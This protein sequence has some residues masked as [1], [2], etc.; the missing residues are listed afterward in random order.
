MPTTSAPSS[1]AATRAAARSQIALDRTL[2]LAA[3]ASQRAATRPHRT[4][5]YVLVP[6]SRLTP[7]DRSTRVYSAQRAAPHLG[8][9]GLIRVA[10]KVTRDLHISGS[11]ITDNVNG[12]LAAIANGGGSG[13]STYPARDMSALDALSSGVTFGPGFNRGTV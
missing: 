11:S 9:F 12:A 1:P 5:S 6:V 8:R 2:A 7:T 10:S 4:S 13:C 3:P